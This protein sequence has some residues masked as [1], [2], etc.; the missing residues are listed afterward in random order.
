[1]PSS[2]PQPLQPGDFYYTPEGYMVFTEQYHLRR[3]TCCGNGCRHCP[4]QLAKEKKKASG[5]TRQ[6]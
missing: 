6:G 2:A 4:W 1:M 5:S 3:G